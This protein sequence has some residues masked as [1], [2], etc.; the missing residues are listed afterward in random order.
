MLAHICTEELSGPQCCVVAREARPWCLREL[1]RKLRDA[2]V[3]KVALVSTSRGLRKVMFERDAYG[4]RG[5]YSMDGRPFPS[6]DA[7]AIADA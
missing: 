5:W 7:A 4:P 6:L 1:D 3:G 2:P